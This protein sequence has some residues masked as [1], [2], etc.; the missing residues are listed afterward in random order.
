MQI[1]LWQIL[2]TTLVILAQ[3]SAFAG[4]VVREFRGSYSTTTADFEVRAPWILDW[5]IVTDYPGQMGLDISLVD[6][7]TGAFEGSVLKTQW[8]GN[9]VRLFEEGGRFQ[10]KVVSNLSDWTLKV[11]QLSRAEAEQHT[12]R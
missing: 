7:Q 5:R 6:A 1:K 2:A 12:P 9:G 8:P 10:F 4:E 11:E 3:N